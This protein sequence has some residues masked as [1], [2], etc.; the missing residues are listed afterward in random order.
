MILVVV[1]TASVFVSCHN[2]DENRYRREY[3]QH[4]VT[5]SEFVSLLCYLYKLDL[6]LL[7]YLTFLKR[8]THL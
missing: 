8:E 6:F 3:F 1:S 7:D 2:I 4:H 5:A